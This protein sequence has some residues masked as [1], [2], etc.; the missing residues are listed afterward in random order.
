MLFFYRESPFYLWE[1]RR[2]ILFFLFVFVYVM[3]GPR[4]WHHIGED[5]DN[6]KLPDCLSARRMFR[7]CRMHLVINWQ[8]FDAGCRTP[9]YTGKFIAC[10][11]LKYE[12]FR[13]FDKAA[14]FMPQRRS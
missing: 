14:E 13:H 11:W 10:V 1:L 8:R 6:Y 2:P 5:W 7:F 3:D 12:V 4:L 9:R